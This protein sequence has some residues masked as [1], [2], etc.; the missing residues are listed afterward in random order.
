MMGLMS[1]FLALNTENCDEW[2][3]NVHTSYEHLSNITRTLYPIPEPHPADLAFPS[4]GLRGER[5]DYIVFTLNRDGNLHAIPV[6]L[7]SGGLQVSA[8]V[9]QLKRGADFVE[10]FGPEEPAPICRPLLIHGRVLSSRDRKR[11]N[12]LKIPFR[13]LRLTVKTT[14]CGAQGN[15]AAALEG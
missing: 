15:L 10:R 7:K 11:L 14:R 9:R 1:V 8:T 12:R 13:G 3:K 6:E 5:C 2:R 4:H